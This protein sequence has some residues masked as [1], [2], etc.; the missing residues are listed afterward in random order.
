MQTGEINLDKKKT[1]KLIEVAI[2]EG[3][4]TLYKSAKKS[5]S[6]LSCAVTLNE[7]YRSC[8]KLFS[9]FPKPSLQR[10]PSCQT[11][12]HELTQ[13]FTEDEISNTL[14]GLKSKAPSRNGFSPFQLKLA[15]SHITAY[16]TNLF[17]AI[18]RTSYFPS[19]WLESCLFFIYKKG[20]QKD[21][22][23][24]RSI[25]IENPFLK[26]FNS[27]INKRLYKFA[28]KC[29]LLPTF[30]FG[31]RKNKSTV[32]AAM[33]LFELAH[34]RINNKKRLYTCF[35]DFK[36]AFDYVDRSILF[37]KLQ[38]LGVPYCFCKL[39]F[40][41]LERLKLFIRDGTKLSSHLFSTNGVPQGDA[42]SPLL[43]S[44]FIA[45]LP[46]HLNFLHPK[47]NEVSTGYI[48]YADDL[49]V[50]AD[51]KEELQ[52][53]INSVADYCNIN[54][55]SINAQKTQYLVFHKGRLPRNSEVFLNGEKLERSNAVTY[56]GF[57]FTSQLRFSKH[58]FNLCSKANA[59]IG[60]LF[61]KL[62]LAK[63]PLPIVKLVFETYI[64]PIFRY[65]LCIYF[66]FCSTKAQESLDAVFTKFLKRY[67]RVPKHSSDALTHFI[68]NSEPLTLTLRNETQKSF[69]STSFPTEFSGFRP[70]LAEYLPKQHTH[71]QAFEH[72]PHHYWHNYI[73]F[74]IPLDPRYR[75]STMQ[76]CFDSIHYT[77]CTNRSFH[78]QNESCVCKHC[79]LHCNLFHY[80]TCSAVLDV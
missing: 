57:C 72:V 4:G 2:A 55:L 77:L 36:K 16:I 18:L 19:Q 54:N 1:E 26:A 65:G 40:S 52:K 38:K 30:Q 74:N 60:Y 3:I 35:F 20:D 70:A 29:N 5:P 56:L 32:S 6:N 17:N 24:Y 13:P 58:V 50:M 61:S 68:T 33:V 37:T 25:S 73:P 53:A 42:L 62:P 45:D 80:R 9:H 7:F 64:L 63:L 71:Y 10:L 39:I 15:A 69:L 31:F 27:L 67:L 76:L 11:E 41:M 28:E 49:V 47:L 46:D 8:T 12:F 34:S 59:R 23:N 43:F 66:P 14:K 44:L 48:L 22:N 75:H 79:Q 78:F 21:P 51:S